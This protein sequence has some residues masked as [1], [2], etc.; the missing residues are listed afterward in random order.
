MA[1]EN[2]AINE[3]DGSE[4]RIFDIYPAGKSEFTL[5]EDDGKTT[6]Y[7]SGKNTKTR[8]SSVVA[9]DKVKITVHKAKG[10]GYKGMVKER[11]TEFLVN[12]R[13]QPES[14]T[15]K[16]GGKNNKL[17]KALTEEE[18]SRS[19]NVYFYNE[20]PNLNKY[21]T[22]GSE[23]AKTKVTTAPKLFVKI[24]KTDIT[25]NQVMLTVNGF[26][27][28]QEKEVKDTEVPDVP[29]G[30]GAAD[31][32][33]TDK[34]IK[35][36]WNKVE[37]ENL[38]YDLKINGMIY[39]NVYFEKENE[40]PFFEHD[41]LNF[42]TEYR[43]SIR[44]VNTKGASDWSDE[45]T[46]KTKLDRFRNVPKNMTANASSNQPGSEASRAVDG[47]EKT[48]WHT[49]WGSGN[50][51]PHT[52]E[53]DMKLAYQLDKLEYVPRPD[54]GNGTILKYDLDVSLDGKTY[55]NV[56]TDGT[57]IR[58]NETKTIQFNEEVTARYIKLT[59]KDAVGKFGSAQE[60]RPYKKDKTEGMVVG[61]NIPNGAIDE[62]DLLFFASYMGVDTT[63]TSW[64]Q[65][66][67]VD[68][69]YNGVIDS[70]DLMYVAGQL[71]ETQLQPTK[72][73][74]AGL[75]SIRPDKQ[76]LKAGE[77]FA[78]EVI[79]AGMKDINAFNLELEID[80]NKYEIV[81][82]CLEGSECGERIAD[83]AASTANMLNYSILAGIGNEKQRIMAAFS[84]K[85][86][87]ETLEG[88][89]TLAVIKL[90]ARKI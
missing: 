72:R 46:V 81:K 57:F 50:V 55:K 4:N 65:V 87:F 67:K 77:E 13:K 85:G 74:A 34:S 76:Q 48:Q 84:N 90:K 59:I 73:P 63:D 17:R 25:K 32:N 15:V 33:I 8:I 43:Y 44:A 14:V 66:S 39:K 80:P 41:N 88:T 35:L 89:S 70:Y 42:D 7:K 12:T 6:D 51:L 79:G 78:V 75:L 24:A 52:F 3:L 54:A 47:D 62:E 23:F 69:N 11:G 53:I 45:I 58:S 26:N 71:G 10:K 56:I 21:S 2:N 49:A 61:E 9:N 40:K 83:S 16:V 64:D 82:E 60:F 20:S 36:N 19:E 86:S 29:Y 22:E 1:P 37:G 38:S 68:I 27:N 30:L 5:Y 31:E 28:T 18:Y